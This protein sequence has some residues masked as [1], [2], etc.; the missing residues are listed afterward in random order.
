MPSP[1]SRATSRTLALTLLPLAALALALPA[2]AQPGGSIS[3][4]SDLRFRGASLSDG[5]P[6][7]QLSIGCELPEG[8]YGGGMLSRV[9][10]GQV[11]QPSSSALLLLYAGRVQTLTPGLD[12]DVGLALTRMPSLPDSNYH[13]LHLGLLGEHWNA[14]LHYSP[15]YF[16]RGPAS[17]YAELN[18]HWP[19]A[20]MLRGFAHAGVLAGLGSPANHSGPRARLDLRAGAALQLGSWDWQL[21]WTRAGHGGPYYTARALRRDTLVLSSAIS[22]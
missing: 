20:P 22:F 18:T 6:S 14:R 7:A 3:W 9:R 5:R 16:G 1:H 12:L 19:I 4:Q 11:W 2:R 17:L 21:A 8:W 13:E 10:F 15:A